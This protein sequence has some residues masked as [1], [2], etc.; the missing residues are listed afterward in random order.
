MK[1]SILSKPMVKLRSLLLISS[2]KVLIE[3]LKMDPHSKFLPH[4]ILH[5]NLYFHRFD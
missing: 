3:H 5:L 1:F 2:H 4:Q